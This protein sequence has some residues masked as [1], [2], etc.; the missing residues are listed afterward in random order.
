MSQKSYVVLT[1]AKPHSK[2]A[3]R[4]PAVPRHPLSQRKGR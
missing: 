2:T 3:G 1:A 4:H